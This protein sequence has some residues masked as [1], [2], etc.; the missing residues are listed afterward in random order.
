MLR[1]CQQRSWTLIETID[2]GTTACIYVVE[3][4][5]GG[6]RYALKTQR[7]ASLQDHAVRTEYRV[8]EYLKATPM[9]QAVPRVGDWLPELDGFLMDLLRY[10]T[11]AEVQ[12]LAWAPDLGRVLR[13]LHSTSLPTVARVPDDRSNVAEAVSRRFRLLFRHVLRRNNYWARLPKADRPKLAHVRAC[14]DTYAG[15]LP[16]V[17]RDLADTEPSLTHGDLA[18]DN[19]MLTQDGRLALA[20]WGMARISSPLTDV[21]N[22]LTYAQ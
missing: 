2:P 21:A 19:T 7:D 14:Y 6:Q 9:R 11:P 12:A 18:G 5:K 20:D 3:I 16:Q 17:E 10:P 15:L 13:I 22:L 4:D 1:F 8:L